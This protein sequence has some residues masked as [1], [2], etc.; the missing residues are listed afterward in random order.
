LNNIGGGA[1]SITR[2]F[3]PDEVSE[4][5]TREVANQ[6]CPSAPGGTRLATARPMSMT[7]YLDSCGRTDIHVVPLYDPQ[8]AP[9]DGD[10]IILEPA[11]RFFETQRFF[12]ALPNSGMTR[13]EVRVG[14][15]LAS[16]IYRFDQSV[17]VQTD[18]KESTVTQLRESLLKLHTNSH[19][20]Q[21]ANT[22]SAVAFLRLPKRSKQ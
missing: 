4:F 13:R 2:Y 5:D 11:R 14:P 9:R 18:A 10:L 8:Y 19:K 12:D 15:V 6:V 20:S 16:T 17:P 7:Y 1:R 3:A 21:P 22:Y